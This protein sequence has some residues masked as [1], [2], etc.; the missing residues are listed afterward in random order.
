MPQKVQWQV[1][2]F[3]R[4][5]QYW[6][7]LP[8]DVVRELE[9]IK[10]TM[11]DHVGVEWTYVYPAKR[12]RK[13]P[14]GTFVLDPEGNANGDPVQDDNEETSPTVCASYRLYP[15]RM[16]QVNITEG[17]NRARPLRRVVVDEP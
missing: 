10:D 15:K 11:C 3:E 1:E 16:V 5:I 7:D 4:G 14:S 17:I 9:G 13:N 2:Y 8:P 12:S 6:W